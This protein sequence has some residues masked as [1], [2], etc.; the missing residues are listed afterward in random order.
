MTLI[1]TSTEATMDAPAKIV[2]GQPSFGPEEEQ[3]VLETIRSGW[4]GQGPLV[5]RFETEMSA[6]LDVPHVVSVSSCTAAL[7]LSLLAAEIGPGDEVI[8][9]PFTFVATVNA[10]EHAGATPVFV[11]VDPVSLCLTPEDAAAAITPRTRAIMP[12]HFGGRPI[13][14][15]GYEA[16]ALEHDLWIVEDAAHAIGTRDRGRMVGSPTGDRTIVCFSFYPNKNLSTCEGGAITTRNAE[17]ADRL[18][19]LRL[20]GLDNDAWRRYQ[21]DTYRPSMAVLAGYKYNWT[22]VQAAIALPQLAKLE[23]F[24]ARRQELA[25]AYDAAFRDME[26]VTPVDRTIEPDSRHALHLYQVAV[27]EDIRDEVLT[28]LR[29]AG[30]GAAVHYIGVNHH[31]YYEPRFAGQSFPVSDRSSFTLI[32]LPLHVAMSYEDVERVATELEAARRAALDARA[33]GAGSA[34]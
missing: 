33:A 6:Y 18:Q 11:D 20:H 24:L 9:T 32:T 28:S 17:I 10:I 13:D 14:T 30:V 25:D 12:V 21:T 4:I 27:D 1:D 5:Q 3:L 16:L 8:T 19:K 23:Q 7:H 15:R 22:D 29:G 26:G 31:P 2:F 34:R